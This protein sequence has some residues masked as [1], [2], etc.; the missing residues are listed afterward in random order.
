M[1]IAKLS[2]FIE[3]D[4]TIRVK[5]W[6]KHS[7]LDY[8]AKHPILLTAKHLDIQDP[9]ERAH[10]ENLHEARKC[11]NH[12]SKVPYCWIANRIK[13]NQINMYQKETQERQRNPPTDGGPTSRTTWWTCF[14]I[15]PN[16]S[17]LIRI[18]RSEVS[19]RIIEE[20]L[21]PLH[22]SNSE[23]AVHIKVAQSIDT[24]SCLAAVARFLASSGYQNTIISNNGTNFVGAAKELKAILEEWDKAKIESDL[25][26]KKDHWDIQPSRR[27][28]PWKLGKTD[29]KL[30]ERHD[31]NPGKLKPP[32]RG[33]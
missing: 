18:H 20:M 13:K 33:T 8:N 5:G 29:S 7:N 15:H 10:R 14:P 17:Q 27:P 31:C 26:Q 24:E 21:L 19:R 6:R 3:E 16:W 32:R 25:P 23:R 11:E 1:D 22:L 30:P 2:P 9:L 4:W 12:S 28:T